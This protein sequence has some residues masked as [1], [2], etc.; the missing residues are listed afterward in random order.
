MGGL[1]KGPRWL[2]NC[3]RRGLAECGGEGYAFCAG[4]TSA[5]LTVEWDLA[6]EAALDRRYG[7]VS[8]ELPVWCDET[9]TVEGFLEWAEW[10]VPGGVI[11]SW[12]ANVEPKWLFSPVSSLGCGSTS[13]SIMACCAWN[14]N[15]GRGANARSDLHTDMKSLLMVSV[16]I[17]Y[18]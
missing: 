3:S 6:F 14:V 2:E 10:A 9:P 13:G 5:A 16:L 8:T 12:G 15:Q 11:L 18:E 17:W 1:A 4:A 7:F